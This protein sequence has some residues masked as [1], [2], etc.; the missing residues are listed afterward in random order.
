LNHQ[1]P[2]WFL[3]PFRRNLSQRSIIWERQFAFSFPDGRLQAGPLR[4]TLGCAPVGLRIAF[5]S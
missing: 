1:K 5:E 3:M 4:E 2:D